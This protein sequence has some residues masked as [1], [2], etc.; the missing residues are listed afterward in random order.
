[1]DFDDD[2][3]EYQISTTT[4]LYNLNTNM[5][6]IT[7]A[8][9][10]QSDLETTDVDEFTFDPHVD[11]TYKDD[12]QTQIDDMNSEST[13]DPNNV[14]SQTADINQ[15]AIIP[16]QPDNDQ[17]LAKTKYTNLDQIQLNNL[18]SMPFDY[19]TFVNRSSFKQFLSNYVMPVKP[20]NSDNK[21][22][23]TYSDE[24]TAVFEFEYLQH[25]DLFRDPNLKVTG[26][27]FL[28]HYLS[29]PLSSASISL[30]HFYTIP[31]NAVVGGDF[32]LE[33]NFSTSLDSYNPVPVRIIPMNVTND[34]NAVKFEP[35]EPCVIYD[36][37]NGHTARVDLSVLCVSVVCN[38]RYL[39]YLASGASSIY[40]V[41]YSTNNIDFKKMSLSYE[42]SVS[43]TIP[44]FQYLGYTKE[45][46][47][48]ISDPANAPTKKAKVFHYA[49][50]PKYSFDSDHYKQ[51][52]VDELDTYTFN[53]TDDMTN[54]HQFDSAWMFTSVIYSLF[55]KFMIDNTPKDYTITFLNP[56][57][58]SSAF[59]NTFNV[60]Y[61][62][63]LDYFKTII[64]VT[65]DSK[66]AIGTLIPSMHHFSNPIPFSMST[67][68][69]SNVPIPS[70]PSK[71]SKP[72]PSNSTLLSQ[73]PEMNQ[74][75]GQNQS[76]NSQP[77]LTNLLTS[78]N[79]SKPSTST[80]ISN[81]NDK[82]QTQINDNQSPLGVT[83]SGSL[84]ASSS[85]LSSSSDTIDQNSSDEFLPEFSTLTINDP[86]LFY[87]V[88]GFPA[89]YP[90]VI[91]TLSPT[92]LAN[93]SLNHSIAPSNLSSLPLKSYIPLLPFKQ[94]SLSMP[95]PDTLFES[96]INLFHSC[97]TDD[98]LSNY[99]PTDVNLID[100][101]YKHTSFGSVYNTSRLQS[102]TIDQAVSR[103]LRD[104]DTDPL[105]H[106]HTVFNKLSNSNL[107]DDKYLS[108]FFLPDAAL[109]PQIHTALIDNSSFSTSLKSIRN[110]LPH[111]SVD[112]RSLIYNSN[113]K[114]YS[115]YSTLIP[116]SNLQTNCIFNSS[117]SSP[118]Q[119]FS[120]ILKNNHSLTSRLDQQ[121]L[122]N[123]ICYHSLFVNKHL[124]KA[125]FSSNIVNLMNLD[126]IS[127][128]N[129]LLIKPLGTNGVTLSSHL[130]KPTVIS[131]LCSTIIN[132]LI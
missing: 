33:F 46:A 82:P 56:L 10:T 96:L 71:P 106:L 53:I 41:S 6:T 120:D 13:S 109:N 20:F 7:E 19:S 107:S 86:R 80:T 40:K 15:S 49:I 66:E 118:Y 14:N 112:L 44:L 89:L 125:Q 95:K 91:Q 62:R 52:I 113:S 129:S 87:S 18:Q 58:F 98:D 27:E 115:T 55:V 132:N 122:A 126:T 88:A 22:Y 104:Y 108:H 16:I 123:L 23:N 65:S 92:D 31:D 79:N 100:R 47:L 63:V 1:M 93:L 3:S 103:S 9:D 99:E 26:P 70:I 21:L 101:N 77:G 76:S 59:P 29:I 78:T 73:Q 51:S 102:F 116:Y 74:S 38:R 117:L 61:S 105:T 119:L 97:S 48:N 131:C 2:N 130:N 24:A 127:R 67:A 57:N 42:Q 11:D 90:S 32:F 85:G 54:Y 34:T 8:P 25:N 111:P 72:N 83:N 4:P 64:N 75:I 5:L 81:S 45:Q 30:N 124:T 36:L 94:H 43:S 28:F 114:I 128:S 60:I 84:Q 68:T 12:S 17:S 37:D 50:T 110:F 39:N 121:I 69:L 35:V